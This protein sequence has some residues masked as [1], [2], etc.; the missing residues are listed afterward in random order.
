M[1]YRERFSTR[2]TEQAEP[3]PGKD[4]VQ[5]NAGGYGFAVD[6][7]KRLDRFLILGS[8]GGSYYVGEK[9]LTIK[10]A[11]AVLRCI[12]S[13]G[14]RV[15]SRIVEISDAGR[16]VKNDPALF[17]LAMCAGADNVGTR[18]AALAALP[19]VARIGTHLFHFSEFVEGFRGW[20][21][22]LRRAVGN[23]YNDMPVDRLSYQAIKYQQRDG[24]SHRD[25]L[26]LSHPKADSPAKDALYEYITKGEASIVE[27]GLLLIEG[28][29][30]AKEATT[31]AQITGLIET[32]GLTREMIPTKW[33]NEVDVWAALL[34]KM[35][36]TAMIRNLGKMTDIGLLKPMSDASGIVVK[37]L[38]NA[39][40]IRKSR[41]HPLSVLIALKIY[42]HGHGMRGS[43]KW[44][45]V[46]EIV[47]TLDEAF[48][49]SFSNIEPT[50]KRLALALDVS[51]SMGMQ[52]IAGMPIT[53]REA[54]AAMAMVT[55]RVEKQY[56]ITGFSHQLIDLNISPRQRLDDV[57][58]TIS[59]V[60]F[61]RTDCALPIMMATKRNI[62]VDGFVICTDN[63][64]WAGN[65]HPTQA[66]DEYR[67]R[68][69]IPARF[70]T[71]GMTASGFT[72]ADPDD[73]GMLDVVGFDTAT[74]NI[75]SNFL[76]E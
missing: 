70:V 8:E 55:A 46:R 47:D 16:A 14:E 40:Y 4:M 41:L 21:R 62:E 31:R 33:L 29:E 19:Q 64:T 13:D 68:T 27:H 3:I 72:I 10:N 18:R 17:A 25:L 2:Q 35:P 23:W 66:L 63:E 75:I 48:Y 24:W 6:D 7:W 37:N 53:P 57:V 5:N 1:V 69:G 39:D 65:I 28:F 73:A 20:G 38:S 58:R 50:G 34:P 30:L 42:Q 71:I 61:G 36:M 54:S 44:E 22:A 9:A 45:P 74:P 26:R 49:L 60:E 12:K 51:G 52:D 11:Q 32:Y 59:G 67:R 76:I 15:V 56:W 43:L